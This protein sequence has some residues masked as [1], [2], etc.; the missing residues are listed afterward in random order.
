MVQ[1]VK[2]CYQPE[3]EESPWDPQVGRDLTSTYMP[4]HMCIYKHNR[5]NEYQNNLNTC[6]PL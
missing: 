2:T 6:L 5:E 1:P 3:D 4:L